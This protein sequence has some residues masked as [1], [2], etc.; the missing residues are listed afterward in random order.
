MNGIKLIKGS[1]KM[2][3]KLTVIIPVYNQEELILRAL[4]SVPNREDIQIIVINDGSTDRTHDKILDFLSDDKIIC[5]KLYCNLEQN[6]GVANAVN[7]GLEKSEGEYTVLL[8]SD[9]YLLSTIE[10]IMDSANG[11]DLIYFDLEINNGDIWSVN[12]TNKENYCGSVKLMRTKFIEGLRNDTAR[13]YG[14]DYYF[15]QDILKRNPIE[16]FTNIV[17]KHYNYPREG[18]LS[19]Q[20]RNGIK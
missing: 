15:F 16:K 17:A 5:N 2:K 14:E 8:G 9:D 19:W 10:Q 18:S 3:Y 7:T 4:Y 1:E 13:K 11:E 12:K 6:K 20:Q